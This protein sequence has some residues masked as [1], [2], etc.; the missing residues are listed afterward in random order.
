MSTNEIRQSILKLIP[1]LERLSLLRINDQALDRVVRNVQFCL[2]IDQFD[3]AQLENVTPMIS[4]C[5]NQ[6]IY[7]RSDQSEPTNRQE[8]MKNSRNKFEDYFVTPSK[9]RHYSNL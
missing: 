7:L 9:H 4:P 2:K 6:S 3:D 5:E 1:L 8:I